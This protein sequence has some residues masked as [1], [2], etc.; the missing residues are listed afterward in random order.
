MSLLQVQ[1]LLPLHQAQ[2]DDIA[3]GISLDGAPS[4]ARSGQGSLEEQK[5]HYE[6]AP[7]PMDMDVDGGGRVPTSSTKRTFALQ[8]AGDKG[9]YGKQWVGLCVGMHG[10]VMQMSRTCA[11]FLVVACSKEHQHLT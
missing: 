5:G 8:E 3:S 10:W 7:A 1:V 6:G 2:Q 4:P 11:H 9:G